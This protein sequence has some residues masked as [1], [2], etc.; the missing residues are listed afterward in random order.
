MAVKHC[1]STQEPIADMLGNI[2]K[3]LAQK[4]L[5]EFYGG[6][7]SRIPTIDYL[8]PEPKIA[9]PT[10]LARNHISHSVESTQEGGEK[11]VYNINGVLPPTGDWLDVLAGPK[12]GWLQAFLSNVSIQ[13]GDQSIPNPVKRV[14]AP[15]HGQRVEL[16]LNKDGSPVSLP[17][18]PLFPGLEL[19]LYSLSTIAQTRRLRW[20]LDL[21]PAKLDI[22]RN[23]VFPLIRT[24]PFSPS[25][26]VPSSFVCVSPSLPQSVIDLSLSLLSS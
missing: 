26:V 11:H 22:S 14:L 1:T 16:S 8:A 4:I 25:L 6:D 15:R 9:D 2:E 10:L 12:L 21:S 13:H 23:S 7:E 24:F 20:S 19:T 3:S 17:T 5:E 18:I